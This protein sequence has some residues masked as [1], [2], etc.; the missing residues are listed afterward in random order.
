MREGTATSGAV[1]A[2]DKWREEL[3]QGGVAYEFELDRNDNKNLKE[4]RR[5]RIQP[6]V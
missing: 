1:H 6:K 4:W 3:K 5:N 2:E